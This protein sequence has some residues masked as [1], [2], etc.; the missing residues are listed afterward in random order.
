M[1]IASDQI[2]LAYLFPVNFSYH[3]QTN[4]CHEQEETFL[5]LLRYV[6]QLIISTHA[7][8]YGTPTHTPDV[9]SLTTIPNSLVRSQATLADEYNFNTLD[10]SRA[11]RVLGRCHAARGEHELSVKAFDSALQL[12]LTGRM[13]MQECLAVRGRA[14]AGRA[15]NGAGGQWDEK[16]GKQR[17]AEVVGRMGLEEARG[18]L[19]QALGAAPPAGISIGRG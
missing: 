5:L 10:R 3:V 8:I 15:V 1:K 14:L 2:Y 19:E 17:L 9:Q 13:L 6:G 7:R 16:T 18:A 11:G 12:A 4:H